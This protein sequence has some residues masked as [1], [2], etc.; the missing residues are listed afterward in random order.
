MTGLR[1]KTVVV[2]IWHHICIVCCSVSPRW[3]YIINC[4]CFKSS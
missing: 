1:N 3:Y 4:D 2:N